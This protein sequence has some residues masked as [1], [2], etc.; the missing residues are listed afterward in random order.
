MLEE[1]GQLEE[2]RQHLRQAVRLDPDHPDAR[3]NLALVCEKLGAYHEAREHWQT[4]LQLDPSSPWSDYARQRLASS[5]TAK[6]A[7]RR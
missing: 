2:A 4:Y 1:L 7:G 6:S 3:Y 5:K